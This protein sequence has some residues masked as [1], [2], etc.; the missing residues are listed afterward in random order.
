V[1]ITTGRLFVCV[2]LE[3]WSKRT[4]IESGSFSYN[5]FYSFE[6]ATLL[7]RIKSALCADHRKNK[8]D[9]GWPT[10]N[11]RFDLTEPFPTPLHRW[12]FY[13]K[14]NNGGMASFRVARPTQER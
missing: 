2:K 1:V 10:C 5:F 4:L 14:L 9:G 3:K 13:Y 7:E 8:R 12:H 6:I 11:A